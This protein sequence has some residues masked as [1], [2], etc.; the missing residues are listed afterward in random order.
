MPRPAGSDELARLDAVASAA[1]VRSGAVS[2]TELAE[3]AI[4]RIEAVD[5]ALNAV[6]FRRYEAAR[7]EAAKV[8]ADAPLAGVPTL[9]KDVDLAGDPFFNGAR[10]YAALDWRLKETD[11]FA[12]RMQAAGLIIL[13]RTNIPE[14]TSAPVTESELH[15]PCRNPWDPARSPGGSSGGAGAAV[16]SLMVP[17]A[18]SSDGGGS[19]RIPASAVGAFTIKPS[20]GG[21]PLA[22]SGSAWLDITSSKSFITRSV[23]DTALLY[24][25]ISGPDPLETVTAPAPERPFALEVGAPPGAL[26]IGVARR[27]PEGLGPLDP[28]ALEA[29]DAAAALL[30]ELGH[31]VEETAPE[32]FLSGESREIIRGYWPMKVAM[33]AVAAERALGRPL[34]EG[35]L[36]P[37]TLAMLRYARKR[38]MADV[39][40]MLM[41]IRTFTTRSLAW[42]DAGHDLLLTPATGSAAPLL[43]ALAGRDEASQAASYRW[44][45][46]APY[47]N[48]TGQPAASVPLHWTVEGLPVGVQLIAHIW[49]EDLLLRVSAQLEEAR[50]WRQRVPPI[51]G[52]AGPRAIF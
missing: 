21:M 38:S 52:G 23:R 7:A 32:T 4:E 48:I 2:A 37:L 25:L 19:S 18:Q 36:E 24:D 20:R 16:A 33:R 41:Q 39:G 6:I 26:R 27:G 3:A 35:D 1:L 40:A 14:F 28:A 22:G 43:G 34:A 49:R 50:P 45:G 5:G 9:I 13:G 42:W 12:Q 31:H 47:A 11:R 51:R 46:L 8:A 17:V 29:V 44:G 30:G 10:A 15:G